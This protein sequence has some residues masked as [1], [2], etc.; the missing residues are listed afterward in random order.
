MSKTKI[1]RKSLK[2][3]WIA[4][5]ILTLAGCSLGPAP[6][7]KPVT[8]FDL[9]RYAGTWYEIA[10][11]DHRFERVLADVSATYRVQADGSVEVR[12]RGFDVARDEWREAIGRAVFIGAP[13]AGSLK[14][15]FFGPFYGGYHVVELDP[16]YR[17]AL[18][19][20]PDRDYAWILARDK[21]LPA[22]VRE[23]LSAA[24]GAAGID[25]SAWVWV[26][27]TRGDPALTTPR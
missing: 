13:T 12:N 4:A 3:L 15:S 27:Q 5:L 10:R 11:L 24:A 19:L 26:T 21:E 17:W 9:A 23:R 8:G 1:I 14:V 16:E 7:V 20:G 25:T 6:G 2:L 22:S 18:V